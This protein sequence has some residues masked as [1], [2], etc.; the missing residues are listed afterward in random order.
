MSADH[1][2]QRMSGSVFTPQVKVQESQ[3]RLQLKKQ[4]GKKANTHNKNKHSLSALPPPFLP[5]LSGTICHATQVER[6][7]RDVRRG[8]KARASP[9]SPEIMGLGKIGGKHK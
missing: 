1:S 9:G 6:I 4:G 8:H 5:Y 2:K 7:L 3:P